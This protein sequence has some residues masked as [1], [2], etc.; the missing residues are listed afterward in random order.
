MSVT[1]KVS[2]VATLISRL[3]VIGA[4]NDGRP[5]TTLGFFITG[6]RFDIVG[7][8]DAIDSVLTARFTN[9]FQVH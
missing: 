8:H 9:L 3:S 1:Q 5:F 7:L 6:Y 4:R 2:G